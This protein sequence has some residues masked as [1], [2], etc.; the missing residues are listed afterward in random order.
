MFVGLLD[1]LLGCE[2]FCC[3]VYL[4]L[5][6]VACL[7]D[8]VLLSVRVDCSNG[9]SLLSLLDCLL[10][11]ACAFMYRCQVLMWLVVGLS[12][13]LW[14]WSVGCCWLLPLLI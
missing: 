11:C 5:G 4:S 1:C 13:R 8:C 3:F 7:K 14:V 10:A 6:L 9:C 12:V 2:V